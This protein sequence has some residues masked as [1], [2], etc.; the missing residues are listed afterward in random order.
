[1]NISNDQLLTAFGRVPRPIR[2]FASGEEVGIVASALA[3]KYKLHV[4]ASG[5]L[6]DTITKTLLGFIR[7][8]ELPKMLAG[9]L[10][11]EQ[12]VT[13]ALIGDINTM[14]FIPLQQRVR[15]A[16][17]A[18][19]E[20]KVREQDLVG[21]APEELVPESTPLKATVSSRPGPLPPL[22]L[23]YEQNIQNPPGPS[24]PAPDAQTTYEIQ[25]VPVTPVFLEPT[26]VSQGVPQQHV[27]HAMPSGPQPGWHPA[28]AVHIFVP[29]HSITPQ[30]Q[31]APAPIPAIALEQSP[32]DAAPYT[33]PVMPIQQAVPQI[34]PEPNVVKSEIP[35]KK[36]YA[37]DPYRETF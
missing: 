36:D 1:M 13:S 18:D 10:L 9:S 16:T 19:T 23:E 22:A 15:E 32:V 33:V 2:E 6:A 27:L 30:Y 11:L 20:E 21:S 37:T 7:P 5:T 29:T 14:V 3:Q 28:A 24:T 26:P 31:A 4:D 12:S 25:A 35:L 8:E 17:T 34:Q